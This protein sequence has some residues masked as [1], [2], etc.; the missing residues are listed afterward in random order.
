VA[1]KAEEASSRVPHGR[2]RP[3]LSAH[4]RPES[5]YRCSKTAG[6]ARASARARLRKKC[7]LLAPLVFVSPLRRR[8]T[9][10]E[11][12]TDAASRHLRCDSCRRPDTGLVAGAHTLTRLELSLSWL[13]LL[14]ETC[15]RLV[16][17]RQC[18]RLCV[19]T[20][21]RVRWRLRLRARVAA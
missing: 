19:L 21:R 5:V 20:I 4:R 9:R 13:P 16:I 18:R 1:R 15:R 10:A 7:V 12:R 8:R 3:R 17:L 2:A 11:R 14:S 6:H